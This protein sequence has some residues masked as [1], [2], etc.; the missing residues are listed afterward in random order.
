MRVAEDEFSEAGLEDRDDTLLEVFDL[1]GVDID[2]GDV[3]AT[4]GEAGACYEADIS[5]S[6]NGNFHALTV[7]AIRTWEGAAAR[8]KAPA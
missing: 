5:R 7:D 2:A 6:N 1:L 4:F 3:V 8:T